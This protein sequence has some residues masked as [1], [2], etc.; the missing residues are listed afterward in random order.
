VSPTRVKGLEGW[1]VVGWAA[2]V[3]LVVGA[4]VFAAHGT[5]GEGWRHLIRASA[6]VSGTIFLAVFLAA[7]LR[8]LWPVDATAWLLR[9]RRGLGV[10]VGLS[11]SVHAVAIYAF[12]RL[13]GHETPAATLVA[14]GVAYG[15]LAAMVATSFDTTAAWLGRR[16]W[17]MLH[18]TGLYYLWFVFGFTFGGTA[19]G[20]DL[21]SAGYAAAY[22]L[23]LPLRLVGLRGRRL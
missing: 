18:R 13:T 7:P 9:N 21:V 10:S 23:A 14:A 8:R 5:D 3:L 17:R 16:R 20:G 4:G 1:V 19:A 11:H 15:F 6:R 22:G 2:L 12:V